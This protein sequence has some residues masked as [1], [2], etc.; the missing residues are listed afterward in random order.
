MGSIRPSYL[1]MLRIGLV[2]LGLQVLFDVVLAA[3]ERAGVT[4]PFEVLTADVTAQLVR[5]TGLPLT[6]S[7]TDLF[8]RQRVL[9]INLECTAAF[10][11]ASFVA[12]V[13]AYP[14][15]IQDKLRGL[16]VGLSALVAA[17]LVRLLMVA[18]VAERTPQWFGFAHDYLFRVVLVLVTVG[19]WLFWLR[20]M[21]RPPV[22]A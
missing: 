1:R 22:E 8:L 11:M 14:S 10:V 17:N 12:L 5:L 15:T 20:S 16:G 18:H 13:V 6:L 19:L 4:R 9:S 21:W 2:F 3:L 7:G